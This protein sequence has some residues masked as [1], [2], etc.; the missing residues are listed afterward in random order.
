MWILH[1]S[2]PKWILILVLKVRIWSFLVAQP[3]RDWVLSLLYLGLLLWYGFDLWS[4]NL[5]MLWV[6]PKR[7][8]KGV[9]LQFNCF[10]K[11]L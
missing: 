4:K 3:V 6:Q 10:K 2:P 5:H 8:K 11:Y 1:N 7:K 9:Y